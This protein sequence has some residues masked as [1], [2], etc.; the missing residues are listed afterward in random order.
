M[1]K[2]MK[3]TW[4]IICILLALLILAAL[5]LP[6]PIA[7]SVYNDNFGKRFTT[8]EIYAFRVEDFDG[9]S[10]E[11]YSFTSDKETLPFSAGVLSSCL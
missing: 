2:T 8:G 4:I 10:R 1:N 7:M 6:K 5:I 11:K 9:L 3:I